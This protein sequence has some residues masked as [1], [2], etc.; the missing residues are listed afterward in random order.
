MTNPEHLRG[1]NEGYEQAL[2]DVLEKLPERDT[3]KI[4]RGWNVDP[5]LVDEAIA[6]Q[7]AGNGAIDEMAATI[8][9]MLAKHIGYEEEVAERDNNS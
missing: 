4:H 7:N 6:E 9:T 1:W 3:R 8:N 2:R 5:Q